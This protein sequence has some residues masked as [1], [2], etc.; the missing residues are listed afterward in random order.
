[1]NC[2]SWPVTYHV[3][4]PD[5]AC[6]GRGV[7]GPRA[8]ETC[9][10]TSHLLAHD[11]RRQ[12]RAARSHLTCSSRA[13]FP[14]LAPSWRAFLQQHRKPHH[15]LAL[16]RFLFPNV[17]QSTQQRFLDFRNRF[18]PALKHRAQ[19][20]IY[21]SL[22]DR[23]A[24]RK[25][26]HERGVF[27]SL[28]RRSIYHLRRRISEDGVGGPQRSK[29][30]YTGPGS[31]LGYADLSSL[32]SDPNQPGGRRRKLAGF[33]R[34]GRDAAQSYLNGEGARDSSDEH[35]AFPD[36]AVVRNGNEEMI[37]FPSYAR[38][39]VKSTVR[40]HIQGAVRT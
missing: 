27:A 35:G 24:R 15:K 18:L 37:L 5:H 4:S 34:A 16:F 25:Q 28:R 13:S 40:W 2:N 31:S 3:N 10:S 21:R 1:M 17:T 38:K 19:S 23:Q 33:V 39:H 36:A 30:A 11:R 22:V 8:H 32:R 26:R 29:M 9:C 6:E 14:T 12:P 20:R 7:S